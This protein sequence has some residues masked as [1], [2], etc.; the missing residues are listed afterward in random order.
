MQQLPDLLTA[1][2][3][4]LVQFAMAVIPPARTMALSSD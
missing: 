4:E 3:E 1:L 2:T